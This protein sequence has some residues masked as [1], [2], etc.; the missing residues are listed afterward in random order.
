MQTYIQP[1]KEQKDAYEHL[2]WAYTK[3]YDVKNIASNLDE[4]ENDNTPKNTKN[5]PSQEPIVQYVLSN[6]DKAIG[7]EFRAFYDTM[8]YLTIIIRDI[9]FK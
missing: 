1:M 2:I 6:L 5:Q 9:I 4:G 3:M 7:H 8:D